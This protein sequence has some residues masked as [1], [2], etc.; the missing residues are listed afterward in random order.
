MTIP[1]LR[2]GFTSVVQRTML[3]MIPVVYTLSAN[4]KLEIDGDNNEAR[5]LEFL[6]QFWWWWLWW[7]WC[8]WDPCLEELVLHP[9]DVGMGL[10][11]SQQL[12]RS[13]SRWWVDF[14][15]NWKGEGRCVASGSKDSLCKCWIS[16][17]YSMYYCIEDTVWRSRRGLM[18][19]KP[20]VAPNT[21]Q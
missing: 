18:S 21:K 3:M 6:P 8:P 2:S 19:V 4:F 16:W 11:I 20:A 1:D 5:C 12:Q 13:G 9:Q 17:T 14:E 15:L 10:G 7:W